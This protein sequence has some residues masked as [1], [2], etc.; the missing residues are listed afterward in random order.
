MMP[1]G[2]YMWKVSATFMDDSVWKGGDIGKGAAKTI[3]T[4]TL[5][6]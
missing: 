3:G 1:Q 2:V 4:V 5:I 6:R